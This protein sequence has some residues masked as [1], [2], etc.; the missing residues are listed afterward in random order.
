MTS[1]D[2]TDRFTQPESVLWLINSLIS[3]KFRP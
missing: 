2:I 1:S 3:E